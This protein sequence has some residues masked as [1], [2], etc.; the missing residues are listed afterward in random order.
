MLKSTF[1]FVFIEKGSVNKN[2]FFFL[3][4][5][6]SSQFIST[7]NFNSVQSIFF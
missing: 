7:E 2:V 6:E 3:T 5:I 4:W 1:N